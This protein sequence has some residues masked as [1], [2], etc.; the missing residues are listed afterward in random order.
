ML[1]PEVDVDVGAG[2]EDPGLM[3]LFGAGSTRAAVSEHDVDAFGAADV[4]VVG[5]ERFEE[6]TGATWVVEHQGAG[7]F[8]LAHRQ[9]PPVVGGTVIGGE[10][11]RDHVDPAV[12]ERLHVGRSEPVADRLQGVRI[13][14]GGEPVGQSGVADPGPVG[15]A[16]GPFMSLR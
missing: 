6:R 15:L 8:D 12:E 4:D 11:G 10:R 1:E 16:F 9:F 5:D 14:A 7:H 2:R 3:R 13:V